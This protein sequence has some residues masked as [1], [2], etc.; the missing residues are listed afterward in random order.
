MRITVCGV[1]CFKVF[2]VVMVNLIKQMVPQFEYVPV[3]L[4]TSDDYHDE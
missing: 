4:L 2:P 3:V 1:P